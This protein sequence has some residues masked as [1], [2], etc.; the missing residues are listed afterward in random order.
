MKKSNK[1][2]NLCTLC[3]KNWIIVKNAIKSANNSQ[4]KEHFKVVLSVQKRFRF[5]K[6]KD[7]WND[8]FKLF[9]TLRQL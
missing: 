6:K 2:L 3:V 7:S 1:T 9:S 8:K 5:Q 4:P